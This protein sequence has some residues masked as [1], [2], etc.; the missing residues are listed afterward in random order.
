M[1]VCFVLHMLWLCFSLFEEIYVVINFVSQ[2]SVYKMYTG[3]GTKEWIETKLFS[4]SL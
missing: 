1:A 3:G 4:T 2:Q